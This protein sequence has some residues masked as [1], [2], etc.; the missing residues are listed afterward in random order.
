MMAV[1]NAWYR[2]LM[3]AS[4]LMVAV[5]AEASIPRDSIVVD[6]SAVMYVA[7]VVVDTAQSQSFFSSSDWWLGFGVSGQWGNANDPS[8]LSL[9]ALPHVS[10]SLTMEKHWSLS[11]RRGRVGVRLRYTQPWKLDDASVSQNV[12]GWIQPSESQ[13]A[14]TPVLAVHLIE[15]N[16]ANERDTNVAPVAK[17]NALSL[18]ALWELPSRGRWKP[19]VAFEL[20]VIRPKPWVLLAPPN[21]ALWEG[22]DADATMQL[23]GLWVGRARIHA[24]AAIDFGRRAVFR[25]ATQLRVSG[26]WAPKG[27]L[28]GQVALLVS[29]TRR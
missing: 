17:G 11:S 15:D 20:D 6:G 16:L 14:T 5:E 25:S 18:A 29:P 27:S 21:P 26:N 28:G 24:G 10:P 8:A 22:L 13:L 9:H 3:A 23:Q 1:G 2:L 4:L 12:K 7:D 19:L